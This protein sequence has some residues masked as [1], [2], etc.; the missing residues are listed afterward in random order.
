MKPALA[1]VTS[2]QLLAAQAC[3]PRVRM[4]ADVTINAVVD[5]RIDWDD[6]PDVHERIRRCAALVELLKE[7]KACRA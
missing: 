1:P 7:V 4:L 2:L 3:A 6:N 5:V